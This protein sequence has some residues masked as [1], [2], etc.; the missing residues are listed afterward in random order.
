MSN[1]TKTA[2]VIGA[3]GLVG[4]ALVK[5][6][7]ADDS[8]QKV[9]VF[10]RKKTGISHEKLQEHLVDFAQPSNWKHLLVGDEL[11][12]CFGTTLKKAG[13]KEKQFEIDYTYVLQTAQAA[14]ENGCT[15][16]VIVSSIGSKANSSNFYLSMKGKL[17]D[18]L[19]NLKPAHLLI[20][21]PSILDG[22]RQEKR[23]GERLGL[24]IMRLLGHIPLFMK[25]RP[26]HADLVA[27]ALI[28]STFEETKGLKVYEMNEMFEL[29]QKY[30]IKTET[31]IES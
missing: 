10:A 14:M 24:A 8:Y 17:E 19:W 13:S 23:T 9:L 18:A 21:R 5:F 30:L 28:Q 3:T 20:H 4:T 15:A 7:L 6:L 11:F 22:P 2:L 16:W 27:K 12:S 29:A 1:S 26:I 31:Q 25:Y